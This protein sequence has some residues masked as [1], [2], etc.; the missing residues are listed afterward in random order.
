MTALLVLLAG[1]VIFACGVLVG[2][3]VMA[4]AVA[5]IDKERER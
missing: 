4:T 5:A 2:I 1:L 3:V